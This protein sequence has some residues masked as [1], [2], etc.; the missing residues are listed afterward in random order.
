MS[1]VWDDFRKLFEIRGSPSEPVV[2]PAQEVSEL[3]WEQ[4]LSD[5]SKFVSTASYSDFVAWLKSE[6][7]KY[8]PLPEHGSDV[9]MC[10]TFTQKG[11]RLALRRLELMK[12]ATEERH[13]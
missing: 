6:I 2:D 3:E 9:G 12:T 11:L 5:H 13:A 10:Y 7:D 8:E 1:G 4:A